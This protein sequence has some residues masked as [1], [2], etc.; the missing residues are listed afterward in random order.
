MNIVIMPSMTLI[1]GCNVISFRR[2][3]YV[4]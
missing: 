3:I 1:T 2:S 4:H